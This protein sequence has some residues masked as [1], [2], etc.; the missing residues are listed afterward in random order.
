MAGG[1][2]IHSTLSCTLEQLSAAPS[3]CVGF[4]TIQPELCMS[5]QR[6]QEIREKLGKSVNVAWTMKIITEC[7]SRYRTTEAKHLSPPLHKDVPHFPLRSHRRSKRPPSE[8]AHVAAVHLLGR[9]RFLVLEPRLCRTY[10]CHL[11][12]THTRIIH[13]Y[14][15]AFLPQAQLR[16][17]AR[18]CSLA[19]LR[20]PATVP[21]ALSAV[22]SLQRA[23]SSPHCLQP[24]CP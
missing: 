9:V 15:H 19:C 20:S 10:Q 13:A 2:S 3:V 24:T 14:T 18:V 4:G 22:P 23:P 8:I 5:N 6:R 11:P 12:P 7:R 21:G 17:L 16:A 1:R